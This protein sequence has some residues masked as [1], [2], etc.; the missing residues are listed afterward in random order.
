VSPCRP[1]TTPDPA[2]TATAVIDAVFAVRLA[3]PI[4][5]IAEAGRLSAFVTALRTAS[6]A[7][8]TTAT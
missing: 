5:S 2:V 3:P 7:A 6:T 1:A 4:D 8:R